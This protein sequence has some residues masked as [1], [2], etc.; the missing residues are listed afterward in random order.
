MS[1][2]ESGNETDADEDDSTETET[3]A[4][5][6]NSDED[7]T[8]IVKDC[9]T[10]IE[11]YIADALL[12]DTVGR[13]NAE[14]DVEANM[15]G[16]TGQHSHR[17]SSVSLP[18]GDKKFETVKYV[19]ENVIRV[20]LADIV[21][22][23]V[24]KK[25]V[26][27]VHE[28]ARHI[29]EIILDDVVEVA[30]K[31]VKS[32]QI[33]HKVDY[34]IEFVTAF[35]TDN[36]ILHKV[37][38]LSGLRMMRQV[39][40]LLGDETERYSDY[41]ESELLQSTSNCESEML[42]LDDRDNSKPFAEQLMECVADRV[43]TDLVESLKDETSE[44][45]T[46]YV[47][48]YITEDILEELPE[49]YTRSMAE[50]SDIYESMSDFGD[51][52]TYESFSDENCSTPR[53]CSSNIWK[54][55][56]D[57]E[58]VGSMSSNT[59][60]HER[61]FF[62]YVTV[63]K[64]PNYILNVPRKPSIEELLNNRLKGN[65]GANMRINIGNRYFDCISTLLKVNSPWFANRDWHEEHFEF[66][67]TDVPPSAFEI[68]YDWLRFHTPI[69]LAD[70]VKVLQGARHLQFDLLQADCWEL[71]SQ[72]HVR[73]KTA[74]HLF[75]EA[76]QMPLLQDVREVLLSRVRGYF[77]ALVGSD[78]FVDLKLSNILSLLERDSIGVN[79]EVEVFFAALLW[80]SR[81]KSRLE[82]MEPVMKCVRF[83]YMPMAMLFSIRSMGTAKET[84]PIGTTER[85]MQE[86]QRNPNLKQMLF[87]A[88]T[89]ISLHFQNELDGESMDPRT[90]IN[91]QWVYPRRW[92]YHPKCP[93]HKIRLIYPYQ[94]VFTQAD[95]FTYVKSIQ[96]DWSGDQPPPNA[97][98]DVEFD[99]V[100]SFNSKD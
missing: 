5:N 70:A 44:H 17:A 48:E 35:I 12:E 74:F 95:F 63:Q 83:A 65:L 20:V 36:E 42:W 25:S 77:L 37:L 50:L 72:G 40:S 9:M 98:M 56:T 18:D 68:I 34:I 64:K 8:K 55:F 92:I 7:I 97:T 30:V 69:K 57:A 32:G 38:S 81:S 6:T 28:L 33:D 47:A 19:V 87:D 46:D 88:M 73:E 53:E 10:Y 91:Q 27:T 15:S 45:L 26:R 94:H 4:R 60:I 86:F 66:K 11:S 29:T 90:E 23:V 58:Y 3:D 31:S 13:I 14:K 24:E 39:N 62:S 2:E 49:E 54:T 1:E 21:G 89:Y 67:E 71:L 52:K 61:S 96:G 16:S 85:V 84:K 75:L 93:Y 100:V 82:H 99:G 41:L 51:F 59:R 80:L 78:E 22:S 79:C 76:E 43:I